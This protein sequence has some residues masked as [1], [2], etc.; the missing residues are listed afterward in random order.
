MSKRSWKRRRVEG[1]IQGLP[2]ATRR[3]GGPASHPTVE[4]IMEQ[5]IKEVGVTVGDKDKL[6]EVTIQISLLSA[7]GS[8][9]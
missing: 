9:V 1:V 3:D 8:R 6:L 4:V 5:I 2:A 7:E